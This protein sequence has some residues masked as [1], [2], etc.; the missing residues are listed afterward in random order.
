[1]FIDV[2]A[3]DALIRK[4]IEVARALLEE[5]ASN[6]YYWSSERTTSKRTSGVYG[7]DAVDPLASKVD[8]LMQPFDRL[9]TPSS[10]SPLGSLSGTM[11]EVG[12]LCE[13]CDIQGHVA[14]EC[15]TNF[16]GVEHA[17]AM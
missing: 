3:G 4:L 2:V 7:V 14:A 12:A 1:M 15:D 17:N 5:M 6:N 13:I 11:F 16:Q 9:G 10:G 8:A